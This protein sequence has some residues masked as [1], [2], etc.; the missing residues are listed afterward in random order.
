[1][2]GAHHV[3]LFPDCFV[4]RLG[5]A[6]IGYQRVNIRCQGARCNGTFH[7]LLVTHFHALI[8][9]SLGNASKM[10]MTRKIF[11]GSPWHRRP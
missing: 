10:Q 2:C 8:G 7:E 9:S 11:I 1:M 4:P 3:L 6:R 5:E